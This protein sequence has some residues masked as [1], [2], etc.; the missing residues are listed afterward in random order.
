MIERSGIVLM[1]RYNYAK[2]VDER[3]PIAKYRF[4][5]A[6]EMGLMVLGYMERGTPFDYQTRL[7]P[8]PWY[9][10]LRKPTMQKEN[11][12]EFLKRVCKEALDAEDK[13]QQKLEDNARAKMMKTIA[14]KIETKIYAE[15]TISFK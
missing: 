6:V 15:D 12:T 2:M 7:M 10:I 8:N 1:L 14:D 3:N 11:Y 4:C 5:G 9:P 13:I